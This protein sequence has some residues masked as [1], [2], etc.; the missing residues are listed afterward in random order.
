[1]ATGGGNKC[2]MCGGEGHFARECPSQRTPQGSGIGGNSTPRYWT[3]RRQEDT[4]E[5]EFLRQMIQ[6]KK[7]EQ[8]RRKELE[9]KQKMDEIIRQ[10]IERKLEALEARV[11]SKF[12]RQYLAAKEEARKEE[13]RMV[14]TRSPTRHVPQSVHVNPDYSNMGIEDIEVEI[15]KLYEV[16]ERKRKG[17]GP[18]EPGLR[19]QFRQPV[20]QRDIPTIHDPLVAGESSRMG[21]ERGCTKVPAGSGP[22]GI[23]AYILE[24]R[25][26]L[27]A[28]KKI[29]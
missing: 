8:A 22:E 11:M 6:E 7:E 24:Q 27:A 14:G 1:M 3:P 25:K 2:F 16:Q 17:K 28:K 13:V 4:E 5:R 23:L 29:S 19:R 12:G 21:E 20:F 26:V 9:E 18:L 15:A 10:E